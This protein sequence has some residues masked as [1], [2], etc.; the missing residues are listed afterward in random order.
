MGLMGCR[1]ASS[2]SPPPSLPSRG[3][4]LPGTLTLRRAAMVGPIVVGGGGGRS[5]RVAGGAERR[6][7]LIGGAIKR[8]KVIG[9]TEGRWAGIGEGIHEES[10]AEPGGAECG[11]SRKDESGDWWS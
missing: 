10:R 4:E 5:R 7:A 2:G 11:R 9:G 6:G 3:P 1:G 8:G